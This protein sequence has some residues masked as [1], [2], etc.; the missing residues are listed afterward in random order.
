M[1]LN[2]LKIYFEKICFIIKPDMDHTEINNL[3]YKKRNSKRDRVFV[4]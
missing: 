3:V 4:F 1:D 2:Q